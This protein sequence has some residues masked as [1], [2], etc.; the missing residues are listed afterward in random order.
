M[1]FLGPFRTTISKVDATRLR[2]TILSFSSR[3]VLDH[4]NGSIPQVTEVALLFKST[5]KTFNVRDDGTGTF[6]YENNITT[7]ATA[8]FESG[9]ADSH[10][11]Q[12]DANSFIKINQWIGRWPICSGQ[13]SR[14]YFFGSEGM[15]GSWNHEGARFR[16]GTIFDTTGGFS[17]TAATSIALAHDWKVLL[18]ESLMYSPDNF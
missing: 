16:N 6:P 11:I 15:F 7:A 12:I 14:E 4:V 17:V 1:N 5:N 3:S 2:L 8:T 13:R 10:T 18:A 9:P